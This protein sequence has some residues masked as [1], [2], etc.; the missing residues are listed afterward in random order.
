MKMYNSRSCFDLTVKTATLRYYRPV[1]E[2][3]Y[4][5]NPVSTKK[6]MIC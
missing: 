5:Y 3:F 1:N 6:N 4:P 2:A